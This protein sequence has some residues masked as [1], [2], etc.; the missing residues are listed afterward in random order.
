MTTHV[1]F[2]WTDSSTWTFHQPE[3]QQFAQSAIA[4]CDSA[5]ATYAGAAQSLASFRER[6]VEFADLVHD[7]LDRA[8]LDQF[9][10]RLCSQ[11]HDEGSGFKVLF[12]YVKA[13][14]ESLDS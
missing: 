11:R 9:Y 12:H 14:R 7:P 5:A 1:S 10:L 13:L 3:W 2:D 8:K 6:A 4:Y